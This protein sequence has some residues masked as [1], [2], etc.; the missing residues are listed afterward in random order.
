MVRR[1]GSPGRKAQAPEWAGGYSLEVLEQGGPE[2]AEWADDLWE[3]FDKWLPTAPGPFD[4]ERD[5]AWYFLIRTKGIPQ[6]EASDV[7][8]QWLDWLDVSAR[9]AQKASAPCEICGRP[10]K[11]NT[12]GDEKYCQGHSMSETR[13]FMETHP[14]SALARFKRLFGGEAQAPDEQG[15]RERV[16]V[17][18]QE[19]LAFVRSGVKFFPNELDSAMF[20]LTNVKRLDPSEAKEVVYAWYGGDPWVEPSTIQ[21]KKAQETEPF[22]FA[23]EKAT[24]MVL[25]GAFERMDKYLKDPATPSPAKEEGGRLR[26]WLEALRAEINRRGLTIIGQEEA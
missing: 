18:Y 1:I 22:P 26:A 6:A 8:L 20:F 23:V 16:N 14:E 11:E 7:L 9:K 25:V 19:Y 12:W 3:Q 2:W 21:G 17:L 4:S 24:D 5:A 13:K 10:I 15:E